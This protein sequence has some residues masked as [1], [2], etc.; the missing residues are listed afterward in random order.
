MKKIIRL[1]IV[2]LAVV[3]GFSSCKKNSSNTQAT[4]DHEKIIDYVKAQG[5]QGQY[6][7]SGIFY[8][9]SSPGSSQ[10]PTTSS[11][12]T[13]NYKGYLLDGTVFDQQNNV[14]FPLADLIKGWQQGIP[15]IGTGGTIKLIIPSGL[16]YGSAGSGSVPPNAVLVFDITLI[17]FTN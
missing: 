12:V 9:I 17:S 15:L 14:T 1:A 4:I 8:V 2:T 10:H 3:F 6:T 13:V 5:L 7:P 16:G 11:T